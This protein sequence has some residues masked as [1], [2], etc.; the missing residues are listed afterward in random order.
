VNRGLEQAKRDTTSPVYVRDLKSG[1]KND[2]TL[3]KS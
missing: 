1:S 2:K 3:L